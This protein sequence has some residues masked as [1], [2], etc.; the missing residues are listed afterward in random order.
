LLAPRLAAERSHH[1]LEAI[2]ANGKAHKGDKGHNR[3][4]DDQ[5]IKHTNPPPIR[6]TMNE[7]TVMRM[8]I[9]QKILNFS[10]ILITNE[11]ASITKQS[12]SQLATRVEGKN[13]YLAP[14]T[15]S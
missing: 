2:T 12:L 3:H 11:K 9:L 7:T 4:N 1:L 13:A 5:Q 15:F 8:S 6:H 14:I 10:H